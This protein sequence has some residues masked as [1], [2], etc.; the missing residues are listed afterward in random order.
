MFATRF[1]KKKYCL[2]KNKALEIVM[3]IKQ[4]HGK[5]LMSRTNVPT[6]NKH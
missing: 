5:T 2:Y 4:T 3:V 1:N 6:F